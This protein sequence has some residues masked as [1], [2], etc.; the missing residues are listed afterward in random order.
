MNEN[1][2]ELGQLKVEYYNQDIGITRTNGSLGCSFEGCDKQ[3]KSKKSLHDHV[4]IHTGKK[5]YQC[6][7]ES[8]GKR[9]TQYSSLQK[10]ERIH[11]GERPYVCPENVCQKSFSQ[12]SNLNRHIRIHTDEKP[13]KCEECG[14][15]FT[16]NTNKKQHLLTHV[17]VVK[18]VA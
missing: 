9:F 10:H 2:T 3:F 7:L 8:C 4:N 11:K 5:P 14:K 17:Q 18:N 1:M 16:T 15:A 12:I 13:Y 6:F